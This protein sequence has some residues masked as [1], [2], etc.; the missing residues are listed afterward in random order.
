MLSMQNQ[1]F[2]GNCVN[3]RKLL[4]LGQL[5]ADNVVLLRLESVETSIDPSFKYL[6]I[7]TRSSTQNERILKLSFDGILTVFLD[8]L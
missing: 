1:I 8:R 4:P 7:R 6:L 2:G 5:R 3:V